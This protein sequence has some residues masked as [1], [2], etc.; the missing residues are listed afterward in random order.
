MLLRKTFKAQIVDLRIIKLKKK[1]KNTYFM[2]SSYC[3]ASYVRS[4]LLYGRYTHMC[5]YIIYIYIYIE[6]ERERERENVYD[7]INIINLDQF[8]VYRSK[9]RG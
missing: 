5:L 6:R 7:F 1:K 3:G 8:G 2:S 9:I 4:K